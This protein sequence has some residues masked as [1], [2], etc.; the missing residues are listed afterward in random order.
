M[1]KYL[2]ILLSL[3]PVASI[4]AQQPDVYQTIPQGTYEERRTQFLQYYSENGGSGHPLYEVFRQAARAA[5]GYPAEPDRMR[6]VI[7]VIRSNHDC[8]DFT[9]NGL[10]RMVY[11]DEQQ[12]YIPE[13]MKEDIK[14]CILDF[15]YWWDDGRRDTTYRCYHTENH[16]ALYHTAELLAGQLYKREKFTNGMTGR[17]H[18]AHAQ[19]PLMQWLD[20]RFR[21][22]FSEWMSTYYDVEV[23]LLANLFD[24]AEDRTIR[25]KAGMVL[26][27][28]LFD[29]ALNNYQGFLGSSAGRNY[30]NSIISGTHNTSPL[31]KLVFGT[32]TYSRNE[33]MGPVALSTSSYRCPPIICEIATDYHTPL[34][35]RQRV[36]INVED[37]GQY[38]IPYDKEPECHLFWGMQEFIHPLAIRMSKQISE[39]YDVWPYRNY[40]DYIQK[41]DAEVVQYGKTVSN[42]LDRFAL[43]EANIETYRT[44]DYML[45][46]ALDYRKGAPGY[47]QHIWQATLSNTALVYTN[48]PGGNNLRFSPNYWS[49][50]ESLPRAAQSGNVV[51][52]IYNLPDNRKPDFTH[53]YFPVQEFDEVHIS[54]SWIF[55]RKGNGYVALYSQNTPELTTD[56]RGVLCDF[57]AQGRQNI[58]I[59]E[60]G[61]QSQWD[62][63]SR[64][65]EAVSTA[66]IDADGLNV[67]YCSPSEGAVSFGWDTPFRTKDKNMPLR[68][69]YR[70]D[71]P[72]CKTLFDSSIIQIE[73][74][75]KKLMLDL[76]KGKR[77]VIP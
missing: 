28:L 18:M 49:G 7:D 44:P 70:Y 69:K 34:L 48:C 39:K 5:A 17:E 31:C 71:N 64:F 20:Y 55:G 25:T 61:S 2:L 52:C 33:I 56:F 10:L 72:Y 47:Q 36:S 57:R 63:F 40:N 9:L 4:S 38:G 24:F 59:C 76:E 21:F 13:C 51:I 15:K 3:I 42:R 6:K 16:Q 14:A 22:G 50:N 23:L 43:S 32:G 53:G 62:S 19:K 37:A 58:W 8:N 77:T 74:E 45:S 35:N 29:I 30:A 73:R 11:L 12:D 68:W 67:T 75:G 26:D 41:Y 66:S 54:G 60:T 27:L 1:L 46:C 65:I